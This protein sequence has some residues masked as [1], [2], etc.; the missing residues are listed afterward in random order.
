MPE[1]HAE[2]Y[3]YLP[4]VSHKS[5]LIAWGAFYFRT[6]SRGKWKI[7]D[8]DD[9]KYV[10]PPRK[11]SIGECSAP[12]G[13]A[14]V[15]VYDSAGR[16]VACAKTEVA[17]HCWLSGL[18]P[19]T[20]YTYKVFVKGQEWASG[21]R[22][23]WSPKD[24][25]L[26]QSGAHYDN[27]F[28]TNPDPTA[29]ASSLTFAVIGDFGVGV[30]RDT[31]T[32]RQQQVA[33]ALRRMVDLEGV[34]L[35]LTTGDNIYAT[36]RLLG[37]AI[38][39]S[40]D[41][42]DDWFFTYFQPYRYVI[43]RIPVY[44]SIGNHDADETEEHDDRAQVEDNFYLRERM[45]SEEAAGRASFCPGLFYRFRYGSEIEFVC[46]DTSK[47]A[48]FRGHRLFEFPKHWQFIEQAFPEE[49]PHPTWRIPFAHH[50]LYSAGPQHHNTRSMAKLLPLFERSNVRVMF[51]GHEHNFQHSRTPA[52]DHF[53]TGAAGKLRRSRPGGFEAAHT[54]SWAT[55]CHFL[56]ARIEGGRMTVRAIA[57][58][59]DPN[60]VPVD[61]ERLH[62]NDTTVTGPIEIKARSD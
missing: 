45:K 51:T 39:S 26:V 44:P 13:P 53:V 37:V 54:E 22:W 11:D 17:N 5:A 29:P 50:P 33:Y 59:D 23:D 40:G 18:Q 31:P 1:F 27:R 25:A 46:I 62:P 4:A 2:P 61:I 12:Y 43:N 19:D 3:I 6:S 58:I 48:F 35:L 10:H 47:E 34:R 9:L 28:R 15:E 8:D 52:L 60:A 24:K 38:G 42:D 7:V 21:E 57:P 36:T 49:G 55:E 32:R 14:K 30:K 16:T 56:L 41:E 20:E